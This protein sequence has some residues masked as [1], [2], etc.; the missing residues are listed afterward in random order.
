MRFKP[1]SEQLDTS[2]YRIVDSHAHLGL[3]HKFD[4]QGGFEDD[5]VAQMDRVGVQALAISPMVGLGLDSRR[6]NDMTAAVIKKYPDRFYGMA[7][8]SGNRPEEILPELTRCFDTLGMTMIKLH[9]DE[10]NC[11]MER[12]CYD[13]IYGFAAE[14]KLAIMNH[15]W[16]SPA[17]LEALAK[18]YP[19]VRF[20]QA[21]SG[22]NWDGHREDDY[23]RLARDYENVFVDICASPIFY[24]ALESLVEVAGA[25]NILFGSDAPF[26]NLAFGVGKVLLADLPHADKQKIFADNFLGIIAPRD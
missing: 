8:A 15:D 18:R 10:A 6:A 25:D 9:P 2:G 21:H 26:L 14:R 17:R 11:P 24:G 22:G 4:I 5:L 12:K 20:T 19:Q 23:F 1:L 13:L 3:Y 16:Q 7:L